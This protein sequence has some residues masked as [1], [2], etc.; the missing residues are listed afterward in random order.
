MPT[1]DRP[2]MRR[3]AGVALALVMLSACGIKGDLAR[4]QPLLG[5]RGREPPEKPQPY[6]EDN[7]DEQDVLGRVPAS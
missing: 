6:P 3:V 4:G 7:S 1:L 2:T 5:D